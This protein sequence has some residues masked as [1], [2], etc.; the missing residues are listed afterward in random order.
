MVDLCIICTPH[1]VYKFIIQLLSQK[2]GALNMQQALNYKRMQDWAVMRV[3][4]HILADKVSVYVSFNGVFVE[5]IILY[6]SNL[7]QSNYVCGNSLRIP[8]IN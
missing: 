8:Y 1:W 2:I 3:R 5:N 7:Q 6:H 4:D